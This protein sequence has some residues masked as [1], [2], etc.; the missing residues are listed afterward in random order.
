[1]KTVQQMS[2]E[3]KPTDKAVMFYRSQEKRRKVKKRFYDF[4]D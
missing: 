3:I 4:F 2:D 1:M